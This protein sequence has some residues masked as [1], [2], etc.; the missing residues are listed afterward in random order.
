MECKHC[1][2]TFED[3]DRVASISGSITGDEHTDVYFLCPACN[4]YTVAEW[5]DNFT[6]GEETVAISG[7]LSKEEGDKRVALIGKCAEP[8]DKKCRCDAH[9]EYFNNTLD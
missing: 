2:R 4:Q 3:A 5:R 9:C 6:G 8:W 1:N 7:P